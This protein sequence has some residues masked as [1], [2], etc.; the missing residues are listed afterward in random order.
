MTGFVGHA[1]RK[2]GAKAAAGCRERKSE[3]EVVIAESESRFRRIAD[4]A[5]AL[6]WVSDAEGRII[7]ANRHY[8][9]VFGVTATEMLGDGWQRVMVPGDLP[10]FYAA[11]MT[12]FATHQPFRTE[13]RFI[14]KDGAIRWYRC[15]GAPRFDTGGTFLGY[16]GLNIDIS[17]GRLAEEELRRSEAKFRTIAESMPQIVWSSLPDGRHD[18]FNQ[19]WFEF[20]G[21]SEW[22]NARDWRSIVHPQDWPKAHLAWQEAL[23]TGEPYEYEFRLRRR[24]GDYQWVLA[25]ALPVYEDG[26]GEIVRWFGTCT[27]IEDQIAARQA[28]ARSQEE[29]EQVVGERTAELQAANEKLLKE[30]AEREQAEEALRQAQKMEAVGQLTGGVAHDFNNLLTVISG[31]LEALLRR[32]DKDEI[33]FSRIKSAAENAMR[34]AQRAATLTERLLAF[35]RRQPLA[36]KPVDPNRLVTEMVDLLR[37]TLGET[38][39]LK[40]ELAEDAWPILADVNHL[41]SAILNLAVNARDAMPEG[42]VLTI[43]TVNR[44][45][46]EPRA[47]DLDPDMEGG[48]YVCICVADTGSG[49]S[50]DTLQHAFDP[51]FT[52]KEV[53]AGTGLGLS[54]VYGF[55]K[56]SEGGITLN[57]KVGQGTEVCLFLRRSAAM[58][59]EAK[60]EPVP[61]APMADAA[62]VQTI[63]V[64]ED[65][66]DVRRY[67][68]SL[69]EELGYVV[70]SCGNGAEALSV[71]RAGTP[72]DLLFTD[73]GLPGGLNGRELAEAA[74]ELRPELGVLFATAYAHDVF[75]DDEGMHPDAEILRKPFQ[76]AVLAQRVS[77]ILLR[78]RDASRGKA[79]EAS[80]ARTILVVEDEVL[81]SILAVDLLE[82]LGHEAETAANAEDAIRTFVEQPDRFGAIMVDLGLP[83]RDGKELAVELRAIAP[84]V[85]IIFATG[86]SVAELEA[87]YDHDPRV[88]VLGKPYDGRGLASVLNELGVGGA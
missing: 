34:G 55:L 50:E 10:S 87:Q 29:L 39:E 78:S 15:E 61:T 37:R 81:I 70:I 44:S 28:L 2:G 46:S 68:T 52:T 49:M 1:K 12:A 27:D 85:P 69:L 16:T 79:K 88:K 45:V 53:G 11:F 41:E 23:K 6:I 84:S 22:E 36:P 47:S 19:R 5:P 72:V 7:F 18:Y 21:H 86:H 65:D 38:I 4:S 54:Q 17:E 42:G 30:I 8:E 74:K 73:V 3:P 20:T 35:A 14:D 57:S 77:E 25:R 31:N 24:D 51:F 66:E 26:N 80:T 59:E 63:L 76:N 56:Q 64:V 43:Q 67:S 32:L 75:G 58:P 48:D 9:T 82:E 60:I 62:R 83:D 71:L 33:D 13:V 40:T